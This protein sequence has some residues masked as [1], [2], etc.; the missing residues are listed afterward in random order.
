MRDTIF[1]GSVAAMFILSML[2]ILGPQRVALASNDTGVE[3]LAQHLRDNANKSINE[4]TAFTLRGGEVNFAGVGAD[5]NTEVEIGS[6][7]KTFTTEIL[8]QQIAD[9]DIELDTTI[10]D[11][12]DVAG[13]EVADVTM[14]ELA[15]HTSGLPRLDKDNFGFIA[16]TFSE[17]PYEEITPVDVFNAAANA[18]LSNRGEEAYS[19]FGVALLGQLLAKSADTD[20]EE[21]VQRYILDPADMNDTYVGTPETVTEDSPQGLASN[22]RETAGWGMDGY[23]PAGAI[24]STAADMAKYAQFM[25]DNSQFEFGWFEEETGGYWH[26]GG[27]GGYSTML[28]V[29]PEN[30][31]A[32]FTNGNTPQGVEELTVSLRTVRGL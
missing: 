19:N 9:G 7:T 16:L 30:N 23:A 26:N 17:N 2:I 8:R 3:A 32:F 1:W 13:S 24:R 18:S 15:E 22:G 6:V 31:E 12:I 20:Y 5:E 11:I 14:L 25:M 21:L 27:T 29:D 28:V 4:L 10:G